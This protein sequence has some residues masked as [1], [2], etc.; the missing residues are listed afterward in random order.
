MESLILYRNLTHQRLLDDMAALLGF[1]PEAHMSGIGTPLPAAHALEPFSCANQ[2]IELAADYGF[3][4][5][6]WHCFLA[7]CLA[8]HENAYSTACEIRGDVGG[9]LSHLAR[10]DFAVFK[11]LFD[12]DITKLDEMQEGCLSVPGFYETLTRP[13][14]VKVKALGRDG[15]AFE[16]ICEGLLAVCIQHECDHLNGKLFVDYLSN[17]KRDRIRKKLVKIHKAEAKA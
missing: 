16:M 13:E 10:Q 14:R 1:V 17:L 12:R 11:E 8:E 4:G 3:E 5:N 7:F 6:L 9:T 2:L 15:E